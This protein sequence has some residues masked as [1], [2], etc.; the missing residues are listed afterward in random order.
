VL[1]NAPVRHALIFAA[2]IVPEHARPA[3]RECH[4]RYYVGAATTVA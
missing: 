1:I 2:D 3:E 4:A